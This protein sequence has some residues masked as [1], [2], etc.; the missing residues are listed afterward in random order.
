MR[1]M[2]AHTASSHDV[3]YAYAAGRIRSLETKLL[4][5]QRLERLAEA[6]DLDEVL[7]LLAD[8][9]YAEHLD[10]VEDFGYER[11]L[12]NEEARLL[13]LVDSL[14]LDKRVS[15]VFR[16]KYDF[17]NLKVALRET[18][19]GRDLGHLYVELGTCD[20]K[21]F[22]ERLGSESSDRLPGPLAGAARA[23]LDAYSRSSDPGQ[24][25]T[26]IDRFMFS[27]FLDVAASYGAVYV[28][29]IVRTWIDVA[30]IRTFMRARFL[31]MDPRSLQGMLFEGGF[32]NLEDF[33][34]TF[35]LPLE[36]A[37]PRFAF[38]P[39]KRIIEVGG[40]TLEAHKSFVGL[41]REIDS[42]LVSFL[43]LARYF[44]FGLEI[45]LAYALVRQNEIRAMRVILAAKEKGLAGDVIK[46]RIADAE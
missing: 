16:M 43:R 46:E 39:Y 22:A 44:T 7:R 42:Y 45:V 24:M 10:E 34:Q 21:E 15:D 30:N 33:T 37:L 41:E 32:T 28:D 13:D 4:G 26:A 40:T 5:R 2:Q 11:F 25:D 18:L 14:S 19:S 23:G 20:P 12:T 38:S 36:E 27:H 29:A 8:T 6:K 35:A 31:G 17:H 9:A 3:R 1:Y